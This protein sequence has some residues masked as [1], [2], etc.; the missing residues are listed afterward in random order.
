MAVVTQLMWRTNLLDGLI[1]KCDDI[2]GVI[3]KKPILMIVMKWNDNEL[4][5]RERDQW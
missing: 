3:V 4:A 2:N 5:N 1:R